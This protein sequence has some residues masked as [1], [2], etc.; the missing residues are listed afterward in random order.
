MYHFF[1]S[2][3]GIPFRCFLSKEKTILF[4]PYVYQGRRG[5]RPRITAD[6]LV[7]KM[8]IVFYIVFR[9]ASQLTTSL[10]SSHLSSFTCINNSS[11][12]IKLYK[13]YTWETWL[14]TG[15]TPLWDQ[16][17]IGK[18]KEWEIQT[19]FDLQF[20]FA[21][22]KGPNKL[23]AILEIIHRIISENIF[24]QLHCRQK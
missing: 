11:N 16:V 8:Y 14:N 6:F 23:Q 15:K 9:M 5:R 17:N 4:G 2:E 22:S 7:W 21:N 18:N 19:H 24:Y 10:Y 12:F 1:Q 13:N 20:N 3:V